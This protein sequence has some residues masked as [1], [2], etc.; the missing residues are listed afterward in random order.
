[1]NW[2]RI[3]RRSKIMQ[4]L[5]VQKQQW[6]KMMWRCYLAFAY[7]DDEWASTSNLGS[8]MQE[9]SQVMT[10]AGKLLL[11]PNAWNLKKAGED[12]FFAWMQKL[13]GIVIDTSAE[14]E[15]HVFFTEDRLDK[16]TDLLDAV[17]KNQ[18]RFRLDL[19]SSIHGN[20]IWLIKVYPALKGFISGWRR[21][22]QGV[23]TATAPADLMVGPAKPGEED[24]R[25]ARNVSQR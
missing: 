1:M 15:P 2:Q 24:H 5:P 9:L 13:T 23:N 16:C 8:R 14:R 21:C 19:A 10:A 20:L 12:G 25:A 4:R 11:G 3:A 7:C 6:A 17:D 22:L 18:C